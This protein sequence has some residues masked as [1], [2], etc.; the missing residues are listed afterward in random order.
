MKVQWEK[1]NVD[2]VQ[3]KAQAILKDEDAF[4]EILPFVRK[5]YLKL[6]LLKDELQDSKLHDK[7]VDMMYD[8]DSDN[9]YDSDDSSEDLELVELSK[10]E[11]WNQAIKRRSLAIKKTIRKYWNANEETEDDSDDVDDDVI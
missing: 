10:S 1:Y 7:V 4:D 6:V 3:E 11:R 8:S 5:K 2:E 9:D